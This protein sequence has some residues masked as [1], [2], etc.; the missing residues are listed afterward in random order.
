MGQTANICGGNDVRS[1]DAQRL[2]LVLFELIGNTRI[3]YGVG[4]GRAA[5]E[6]SVPDRRKGEAHLAQDTFDQAGQLLSVL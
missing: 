2:E 1:V 3:E 6:V 4:A 5:A